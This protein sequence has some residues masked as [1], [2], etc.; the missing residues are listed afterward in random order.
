MM[1]IVDASGWL[2]YFSEGE[3]ADFFAPV[4]E[5]TDNLLVPVICLYEVFK[6]VIQMRD[7]QQGQILVSDM[8]LAGRVIDIDESIALSA[9]RISLDFG[10]AMADS[11][12]FA[13]ARAYSATLWTQDLHFHDIPGVK[14]IRKNG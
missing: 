5:D 1:N 12:I 2:E 6:R 8:L 10:L 11:L 3:N 14:W 7:L 13:S 4:I 9:A